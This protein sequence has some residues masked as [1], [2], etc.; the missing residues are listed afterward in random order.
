MILSWYILRE[1]IAPFI[2]G[3]TMIVFIFTMNLLFQMLGKIAGKGIP[4]L[5]IIEYFALNLA[6]IIALAVPM[7]VLIAALSAYGR[8]SSDG[9][10]TALRASGVSPMRLIEPVLVGSVLITLGVG[11]F[12][13]FLLPEMNHR[14]KLL[15]SDIGRKKPTVSIEPGI[16]SFSIPNYVLRASEVNQTNGW[17]KDIT[18]FDNHEAG[19]HSTISSQDGQLRFV[20]KEERVLMTLYSG[21]IHR[22]SSDDPD[23]YEVTVFDSALFRI[24]TPGMM[25]RR[26][27]SSYRGDREMTAGQ[28]WKRVKDL[29][30]KGVTNQNSRKINS[31]LVEIHKKFSI[32]VACIVFILIGA[33]LGMMAHR[34]GIGVSGGISLLFFT[35]YWAFLVGGE[36]L[37]DRGILAPGLAMWSPNVLFALVGIWLIWLA[38]RRTTLPAVGWIAAGVKRLL[39]MDKI[40]AD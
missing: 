31:F 21:E 17:M 13:N 32:P 1:H 2:F 19:K 20:E 16:F 40:E 36:K 25:M 26:G 18:I 12:N 39:R 8:M 6:W 9:E 33:P 30:T 23:V 38:K 11:L 3:L 7:A 5:T 35:I 24:N 15:R 14:T 27:S 37:S 34:G 29:R 4:V 28:M 10:I 22:L